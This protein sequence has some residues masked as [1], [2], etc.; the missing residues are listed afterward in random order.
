MIGGCEQEYAGLN[1]RA[2]QR[3]NVIFGN[4]RINLHQEEKVR[5]EGETG[6][7]P[8]FDQGRLKQLPSM[9]NFSGYMYTNQ[10]TD[11]PSDDWLEQR[12]LLLPR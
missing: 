3:I 4:K 5:S 8:I 6:D 10:C 1:I 2:F 12:L 9:L 11:M 7:H